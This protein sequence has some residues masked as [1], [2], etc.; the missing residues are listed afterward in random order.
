MRI[1]YMY[2]VCIFCFSLFVSFLLFINSDKNK[3]NFFTSY[4]DRKLLLYENVKKILK[5]GNLKT[6]FKT[7]TV[8]KEKGPRFDL[9]RK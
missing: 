1:F 9:Y 3:L 7:K 5:K 6:K 8:I 4:K 2:M